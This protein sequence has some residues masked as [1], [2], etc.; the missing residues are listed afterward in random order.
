MLIFLLLTP[1]NYYYSFLVV[2]FLVP[3]EGGRLHP[4]D[5]LKAA[6]LLALMI[7]ANV[8]ELQNPE[9]L[10]LYFKISISLAVFFAF[11]LVVDLCREKMLPA[12]ECGRG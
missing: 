7:V 6:F 9:M 12:P 1:T 11:S 10:P 4:V 5:A 2:Y 3:F 8:F